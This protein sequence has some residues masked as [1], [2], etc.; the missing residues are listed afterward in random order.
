M[1]LGRAACIGTCIETGTVFMNRA[2]CLDS[3]LFWTRRKNTSRDAALTALG[4][5]TT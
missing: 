2:D 5:Y 4:F 1:D 3:T